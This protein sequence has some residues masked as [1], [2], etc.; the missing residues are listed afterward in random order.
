MAFALTVVVELAIAVPLLGAVDTRCRR[1]FAVFLA[2]LTTH[3]AVWFIWPRFGFPR[4]GYLLAAEAFALLTEAFFYAFVF[5]SLRW[6]RA[7]AV[8]ALANGASLSVGVW[9]HS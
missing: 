5:K 3:P 4:L 2:Q 8:S 7:I 1:V 6:P 9:L